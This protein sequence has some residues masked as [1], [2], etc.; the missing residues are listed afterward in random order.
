MSEKKD[1][2]DSQPKTGDV[3]A[4]N[5]SLNQSGGITGD[6]H[7]GSPKRQLQRAE[8]APLA[9]SL[10]EMG[11]RTVGVTA[12]LG[13]AESY[14]FAA[15]IREFVEGLGWKLD[16]EGVSQAVFDKPL[17]GVDISVPATREE[18]VD[19]AILAFG[20]WLADNHLGPVGIA[21]NGLGRNVHGVIRVGAID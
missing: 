6:V 7:I 4:K 21:L 2:G 13:D 18:D 14:R 20:R 16:P 1:A 3:F 9:Q 17:I 10:R 5:V 8:L 19:A 15:Q 11:P 12:V